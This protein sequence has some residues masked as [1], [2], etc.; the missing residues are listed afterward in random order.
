MWF[1]LARALLSGAIIAIAS[2]AARRWPA[3]GGLIVSLPLISILT[4]LWL[5][6]ETRDVDRIAQLSQSTFWFL[7]PSLPMFLILPALLRGG[8]GFWVALGLAVGATA[9]LYIGFFWLA[10]RVGISL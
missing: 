4:F 5:W 2:E 7:L 10:P 1:L 9:L 6:L 8:F 3:V